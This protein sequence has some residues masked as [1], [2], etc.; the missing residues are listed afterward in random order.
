MAIPITL[1]DSA[2][3]QTGL[4]DHL[5]VVAV[6]N[7]EEN[8]HDVTDYGERVLGDVSAAVGGSR[9]GRPLCAG[10]EEIEISKAGC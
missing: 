1:D 9:H 10:G 2:D 7:V 8:G 5:L 6:E 4:L 3:A